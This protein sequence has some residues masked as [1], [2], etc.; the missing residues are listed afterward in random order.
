M[1]PEQDPELVPLNPGFDVVW[2]GFDRAQVFQYI[3]EVDGNVRLLAADRDAAL[4]QVDE[5]SDALQSARSEI[6]KLHNR[7]DELCK[8]PRDEE[9]LDDRL[10][11]MVRLANAQA[12]E[13]TARA[14]AAAEHSLASTEE[15]SN[16]LRERYT[17]LLADVDKQREEMQAEH[18]SVL[19]KA[20]GEVQR[21]TNEAQQRRDKLD[22]DT[23]ARRKQL[24]E[25]FDAYLAEQH[26]ALEKELADRRAS[27]E[28]EAEN[29]VREA[30]EEADRY[31]KEARAAADKREYEANQEVER[32]QA[33][34]REVL[35]QVRSAQQVLGKSASLLEPLEQEAD[36]AGQN[37]AGQ[38]ATGPVKGNTSQQG[39]QPDPKATR[40]GN[41]KVQAKAR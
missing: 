41:N 33:L 6:S 25:E 37:G 3:E 10:R 19:E 34:R 32:L 17:K 27:S 7:V 9:D 24:T 14:Q 15:L 35:E 36:E 40:H 4:S 22:A 12:G 20:R 13:I 11:R 18:K 5:L 29:R 39:S 28:A 23:E 1:P 38:E 31:L 8:A 21:L 26:A 2:H 30:Q 16:R